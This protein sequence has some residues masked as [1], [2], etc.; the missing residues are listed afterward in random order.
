LILGLPETHHAFSQDTRRL[1]EPFGRRHEIG[2]ESVLHVVISV[3]FLLQTLRKRYRSVGVFVVAISRQIRFSSEVRKEEKCASRYPV[4]VDKGRGT[5]K[6]M[7]VNR[8]WVEDDIAAAPR[9]DLR[10]VSLWKIGR[11][12]RKEDAHAQASQEV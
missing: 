1:G 5:Y 7:K 6:M 10:P 3:K 12:S 11:Q 8:A 2:V 4:L 9:N